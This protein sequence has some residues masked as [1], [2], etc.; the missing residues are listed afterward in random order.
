MILRRGN[1]G[2]IDPTWTGW[3]FADG[4]LWTPE[5]AHYTTGEINALH[6][7][8]QMLHDKAVAGRPHNVTYMAD[9]A[10]RRAGAK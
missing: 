2:A 10:L 1:L 8:L 6:Y 5:D 7:L 9:F 3:R 4:E